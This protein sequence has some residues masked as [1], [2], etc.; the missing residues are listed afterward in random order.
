MYWPEEQGLSLEEFQKR[1]ESHQ[2]GQVADT[3]HVP[4]RVVQS[5]EDPYG[6]EQQYDEP[7]GG[8]RLR[9]RLAS[10][11]DIRIWPGGG[12]VLAWALRLRLEPIS[13]ATALGSVWIQ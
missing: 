10:L 7:E 1:T 4:R 3:L 6:H 12:P 5:P 11:L 2:A 8:N 9:E 13:A